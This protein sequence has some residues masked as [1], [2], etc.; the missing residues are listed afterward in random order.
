MISKLLQNIS[1]D[2]FSKCRS[3]YGLIPVRRLNVPDL[4]S[5]ENELPVIA[6]EDARQIENLSFT[7]DKD[8]LSGLFVLT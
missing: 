5:S 1:G 7:L 4:G 6:I 3:L 8:E 2:S